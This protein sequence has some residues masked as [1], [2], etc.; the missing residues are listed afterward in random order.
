M[1]RRRTKKTRSGS[2]DG[3]RPWRWQTWAIYG[4][5]GIGKTTLAATAPQPRFL[6]SNRGLA[7]IFGRAELAHVRSHPISSL[8]SLERAYDNLTGTGRRDWRRTRTL[9][10]DHFDD[11]QGLVLDDLTQ[12]AVAK[13][14]RRIA[15]DPSQREWGI[16]GN[17]LKRYLRRLKALP[18]HKILIFSVGMDKVS[19]RAIPNLQGQLRNN[20]PYFC[21]VIAYMYARKGE[22]KLSMR[23]KAP[24]YVAKCRYWWL[25]RRVWTFA[26]DDFTMLTRI[27]RLVAAGPEGPSS[28]EEE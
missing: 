17:R 22:R 1:K 2:A 14:E 21:D 26:D 12:A 6:D 7:S 20:L 8:A 23:E 3:A 13:D 5:S 10:L 15:D 24:R 4:D 27:F 9:V 19:D 18:M 28:G 25:K 16:M 11:I